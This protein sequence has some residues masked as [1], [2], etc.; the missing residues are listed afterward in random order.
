MVTNLRQLKENKHTMDYLMN[1]TKPVF[2]TKRRNYLEVS[3]AIT[4][5]R[6]L[7]VTI[8]LGGTAPAAVVS[9]PID[10]VTFYGP[11][12]LQVEKG[13]LSDFPPSKCPTR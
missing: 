3:L 7:R 8:A 12:Y 6:L 9:P 2:A 5:L 11:V 1:L 4:G 13:R 10:F